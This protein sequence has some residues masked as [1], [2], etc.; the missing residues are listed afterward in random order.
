M[1]CQ[2]CEECVY[3]PYCFWC[4]KFIHRYLSQETCR[5]GRRKAQRTLS[6]TTSGTQK[7]LE[8]DPT[9]GMVP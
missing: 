1:T 4:L 7:T 3:L 8:V 9:I 2:Q 5:Q 6:D